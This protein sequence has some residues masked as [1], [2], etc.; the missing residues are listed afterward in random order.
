MTQKEEI[1]RI[2]RE[3]K[4]QMTLGLMLCYPWGYE[5]RARFSELRREGYTILCEKGE[6]ASSN[7]YTIVPPLKNGQ[8]RF[9][10]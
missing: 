2:F 5:A 1:L 10:P 6:K 9:F 7:V 8:L 3:H 4:N